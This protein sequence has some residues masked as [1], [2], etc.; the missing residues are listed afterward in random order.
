MILR[1]TAESR[2]NISTLHFWKA[3]QTHLKKQLDSFNRGYSCFGD[4]SGNTT[5]QEV[6]AE[7]DDG[8]IHFRLLSRTLLHGNLPVQQKD[9]W[10]I[11]A[12]SKWPIHLVERGFNTTVF[13]RQNGSWKTAC[14]WC[15]S[16]FSRRKP[17][18]MIVPSPE[19]FVRSS[20]IWIKLRCWPLLQSISK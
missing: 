8:L 12:Q 2:A 3:S 5:S 7:R 13:A 11:P 4:G 14:H 9:C 19:R 15:A 10:G 20:W 1:E 6:L 16:G 17:I 18:L